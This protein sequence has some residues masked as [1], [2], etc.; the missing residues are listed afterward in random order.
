MFTPYAKSLLIVSL[1]LIALVAPT[2]AQEPAHG[3]VYLTTYNIQGL[4]DDPL[5][6][7][8]HAIRMQILSNHAYLTTYNIKGLLDDPLW[9]DDASRF[10]YV[11]PVTDTLAYLATYNIPELATNPLWQGDTI[12]VVSSDGDTG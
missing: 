6:R 5:W 12:Q 11:A 7:D 1:L 8:F 3:F 2:A 10:Q 4:E 9:R